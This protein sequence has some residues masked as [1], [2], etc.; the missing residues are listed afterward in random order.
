MKLNLRAPKL[1]DKKYFLKWW[2]DP[3]LISMTSGRKE[4][5]ANLNQWF[6]QLLKSEDKQFL[7]LS[8]R[9]PIGHIALAKK[10][11]TMFRTPIIIGEASYRGRGIGTWAL[12]QV[13]E[14]GFKKY[15]M[16]Y[17]EVRPENKHAK[18]VYK[19][20]GYQKTAVKIYKN[21]PHQPKTEVMK[22]TKRGFM[23]AN[24]RLQPSSTIK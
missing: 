21:N 10:S 15:S 4:N 13:L 5:L 3:Y 12:R 8:N 19:D 18:K 11:K 1:S 24:N 20:I 2:N 23:L 6:D 22:L 7:I 14:K 17:L 9:K 16:A